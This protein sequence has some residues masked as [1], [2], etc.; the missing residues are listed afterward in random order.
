MSNFASYKWQF[1]P[2]WLKR[3]VRKR[4]K[5][6]QL[7]TPKVGTY[8]SH[9]PRSTFFLLRRWTFGYSVK[10]HTDTPPIGFVPAECNRFNSM[11]VPPNSSRR[12]G[13]RVGALLMGWVA[14][15]KPSAHH[16]IHHIPSYGTKRGD[17]RINSANMCQQN[18]T[19]ILALWVLQPGWVRKIVRET[20]GQN[21]ESI[22]PTRYPKVWS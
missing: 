1:D 19:D 3:I 15:N 20:Q 6:D 13:A 5:Q 16:H 21:L 17:I 10:T 14:V 11:M 8:L 2:N 7:S 22:G 9:F 18:P 12:K 4:L